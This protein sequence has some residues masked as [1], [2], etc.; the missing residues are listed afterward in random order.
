MLIALTLA[1]ISVG[2]IVFFGHR[3]LCYMRHFQELSYSK[4][5]FKVLVLEHSIYDKKGSSISAI[6]A[7]AVELTK[8]KII[9]SLIISIIAAAGLILITKWEKDPLDV[10]PYKLQSTHQ[11]RGIYN[12][13][14]TAYS[15]FL[16]LTLILVYLLG[17][18]DD[19]ACY[20]LVVIIAIQSTPI[21]LFLSSSIYKRI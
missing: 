1:I 4:H 15:I 2:T 7:L 13:S 12:I 20:W 21:W 10:G 19:I 8:E 3:L 11:A 5:D 16:T 17:A 9:I 18:D 14:L 6:A